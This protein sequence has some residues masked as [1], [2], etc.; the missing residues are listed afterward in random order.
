[1]GCLRKYLLNKDSPKRVAMIATMILLSSNPSAAQ[2]FSGVTS[3][4]QAI[5]E[6]V[7][8]PIGVAIS[9]LAVMAIGFAFMTGRMEWTFAVSIIIGIAI[10]FGAATFVSGITPN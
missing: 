2:D 1:M 8:G 3:F 6:A 7:T 4:L 10:V 9:A 5:V